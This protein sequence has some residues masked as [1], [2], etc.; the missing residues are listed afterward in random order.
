ML[1]SILAQNGTIAFGELAICIAASIILGLIV[2]FC[3]MFRNNYTKNMVVTLAILPVLVQIVILV[4]NGNLGT[5]VAVAGAFSLIRF[6]SAPGS[7][8]DIIS[9]FFTVAI[10]IANGMGYIGYSIMFTIVVA[11]LMLV[12][13]GL[14][15]GESRGALKSLRVTLPEDI[16]YTTVFTDLFEQF[17]TRATLDRVRTTNMGSLFECYYTLILK[18]ASKE[19]EFLD[20]I[21]CRNGNLNISLSIAAPNREDL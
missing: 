3:Y 4:V 9:I 2:S 19:K 14:P 1:D 7:A 21:R 11:I 10:G 16:D 20:A 18:D 17:T 6:R 5:G 8:R 15:L 12:Y 13:N